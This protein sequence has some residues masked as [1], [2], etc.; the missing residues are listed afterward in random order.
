M[1]LYQVKVMPRADEDLEDIAYFIASDS[2]K[3]S[4]KFV[5]EL[6][7]AFKKLLEVFPETGRV[8]QKDVRQFSHKGYT[9]FYRINEEKKLVEV[10]HIVNL[11]KP[12]SERSLK[13]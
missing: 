12:L 10:L 7:D 3:R 5:K 1:D 9:A 8:Y 13:F 11:G 6:L 4:G 2:P